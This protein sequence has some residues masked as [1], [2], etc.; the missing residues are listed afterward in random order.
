MTRIPATAPTSQKA[1]TSATSQTSTDT[2]SPIAI[3]SSF[4]GVTFTRGRTAIFTR[5]G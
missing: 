4:M 1:A 3:R 2:I 5:F